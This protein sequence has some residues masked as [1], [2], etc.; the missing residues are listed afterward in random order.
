VIDVNERRNEGTDLAVREG[1]LLQGGRGLEERDREPLIRGFSKNVW[2][3]R[4][5]PWGKAVDP[6]LVVVG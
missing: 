3:D 4:L 6:Y 5:V 1:K 2:D